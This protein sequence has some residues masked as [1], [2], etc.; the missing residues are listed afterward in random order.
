MSA[1]LT[2]RERQVLQLIAKGY[3]IATELGEQLRIDAK[4]AQT[5]RRNL[6]QKLGLRSKA[7]LMRFVLQ[8]QEEVKEMT[9]DEEA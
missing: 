9:S 3:T 4:T 5:H 8:H 1:Y 2:K 7:Q 6:T